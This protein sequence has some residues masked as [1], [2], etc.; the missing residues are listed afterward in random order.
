MFTVLQQLESLFHTK[1]MGSGA[2]RP[3]V[4]QKQAQTFPDK[5]NEVSLPLWPLVQ[6]EFRGATKDIARESLAKFDNAAPK[7]MHSRR[8]GL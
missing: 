1:G 4:P 7:V 8:H 5:P 2:G 6:Q 3:S